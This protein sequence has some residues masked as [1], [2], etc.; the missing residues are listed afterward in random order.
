MKLGLVLS[1]GGAR[2][3]AHIGVLKAFEENGIHPDIITG[4]SMGG[5]IGA[6]YSLG[7]SANKLAEMLSGLN[8]DELLEV[9]NFF[10]SQK[11]NKI[12]N[13]V[14]Q[15]T[16]FIPLFTKLGF[17]SG[18][19]I[20][21]AFKEITHD[22]EFK[23]LKIPFAC[24]AVDLI[25]ERLITLNS[26]K[27]YEAMYATGAIPPY[28]E[29]L[30]KE[31]MLLADGGILSNAPVDVAKEMGA[32]KVIVVDVNPMQTFRKKENFKNAFDIILRVLDTTLD[33]LYID[34]LAKA[35]YL[36]QIPLNFDI[37]EFEKKDEIVNIGYTIGRESILSK[38][39]K[40]LK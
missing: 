7:I 36:I 9:R 23:D 34:D 13:T 18:R 6:L 24:V 22:K 14:I 40:S 4:A 21:K 1:G 12:L 2:G 17:D 30:E 33:A 20:R 37:F 38:N 5:I 11:T 29:P 26:G 27:L 15:Q 8:F 31:G 25:T 35:D 39:L 28:L 10:Y 32:D 3:L 19:K 16:A